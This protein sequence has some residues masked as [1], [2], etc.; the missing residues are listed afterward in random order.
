VLLALG[1]VGLITFVVVRRI[2]AVWS[3]NS[4]GSLAG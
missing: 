3:G 1:I 4:A 2:R